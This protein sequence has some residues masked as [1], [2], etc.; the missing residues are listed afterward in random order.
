MPTF[1]QKYLK[2]LEDEEKHDSPAYKAIETSLSSQF[3]MRQRPTPDCWHDCFRS[4]GPGE[5]KGLNFDIY[6]KMQ[7][8][9]EFTIGG[10]LK[11]W[12]ITD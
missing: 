1:T 11:Y 5:N 12:N 4:D 6:V 8:P 7:G 9:S 10:V 2:K 3:T